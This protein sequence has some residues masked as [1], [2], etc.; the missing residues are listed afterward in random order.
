MSADVALSIRGSAPNQRAVSRRKDWFPVQNSKL[1]YFNACEFF[2][3]K[4]LCELICGRPTGGSCD[5]IN[6]LPFAQCKVYMTS[7]LG[8]QNG[9]PGLE[10]WGGFGDDETPV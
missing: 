9:N 3:H 1:R 8:Y 10:L 7:R 2:D 6:L 5:G 4:G